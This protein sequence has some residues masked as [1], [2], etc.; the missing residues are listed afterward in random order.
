VQL[1]FHERSF[2]LQGFAVAIICFTIAFSPSILVCAFLRKNIPLEMA[3]QPV[4]HAILERSQD[5]FRMIAV[6]DAVFAL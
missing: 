2:A 5:I 4:V 3:I 1:S 6:D